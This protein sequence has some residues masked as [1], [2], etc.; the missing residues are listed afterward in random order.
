MINIYILYVM[1]IHIVY[2]IIQ[3]N[4]FDTYQ[5][6]LDLLEKPNVTIETLY[7]PLDCHLAVC[8]PDVLHLFKDNFD[9]LTINE[10]VKGK[11]LINFLLVNKLFHL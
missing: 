9:F 7:C 2:M 1:L 5:I 3:K 4:I 10:F 11:W 6:P 8:S